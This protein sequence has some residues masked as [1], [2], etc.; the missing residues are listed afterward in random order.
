MRWTS[1]SICIISTIV[2]KRKYNSMKGRIV[3]M[4][5][6]DLDFSVGY[7]GARRS[8][9]HVTAE[10]QWYDR[11]RFR[12]SVTWTRWNDLASRPSFQ[13]QVRNR[14]YSIAVFF[15]QEWIHSQEVN[16]GNSG[17]EMCEIISTLIATETRILLREQVQ[18]EFT[19]QALGAMNSKWGLNP[20]WSIKSNKRVATKS[21]TKRI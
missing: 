18:N 15:Y 19:P 21:L 4:T 11:R 16:V 12:Q 7:D 8:E 10:T 20:I 14:T 13:I 9:H 2:L 6:T 17:G 5:L 3:T 1:R